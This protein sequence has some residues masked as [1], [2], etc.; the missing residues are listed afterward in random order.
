MCM[1]FGVILLVAAVLFIWARFRGD[2]AP[3]LAASVA[4]AKVQ[5]SVDELTSR[6]SAYAR[7]TLDKAQP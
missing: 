1:V 5:D 6:I 4:K 7:P 3:G 2:R